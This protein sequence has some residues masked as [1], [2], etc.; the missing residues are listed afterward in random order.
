MIVRIV[1]YSNIARSKPPNVHT[2]CACACAANKSLSFTLFYY[3]KKSVFLRLRSLVHKFAQVYFY[4]V[5]F[6][7]RLKF[8]LAN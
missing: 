6:K 7:M 3:N 1:N 4:F 8:V 5:I 2:S